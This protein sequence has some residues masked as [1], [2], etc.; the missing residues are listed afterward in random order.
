[1]AKKDFKITEVTSWQI[2]QDC[3]AEK[4]ASGYKMAM[5][6]A[7]KILDKALT[8]AGYPGKNT[9]EKITSASAHFSNL[10]TLKKAREKHKTILKEL[11]YNLSSID[12]EEALKAYHQAVLDIEGNPEAKLNFI[13]KIF[14]FISYYIPSKKRLVKR[15]I[16]GTTGFFLGVIFLADT[17]MGQSLTKSIV[18]FSHFM[19]SWVLGIFLTIS[20]VVTIV[21]LTIL[22]FEK[23]KKEDEFNL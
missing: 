6:E 2:V 8:G 13:Q 23:R 15:V 10:K 3:L 7:E 12:V 21:T 9:E 14:A 19:F 1:M 17:K 22:Y 18:S 11:S 20:A 4:T 5:I 16:L